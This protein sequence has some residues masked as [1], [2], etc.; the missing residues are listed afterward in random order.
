MTNV[1]V[2]VPRELLLTSNQRL[3]WAQRARRV[4]ALRWAAEAAWAAQGRPRHTRLVRCTAQI[5]YPDRRRRDHHNL[6]PT[7]KALIDGLVAAGMLTD[8]DDTHLLGPDLRP[9][10]VHPAGFRF[11]LRFEEVAA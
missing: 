1:T 7:I 2:D 5:W 8:D 11:A 6:M 3:H 10:G 9:A 4:A